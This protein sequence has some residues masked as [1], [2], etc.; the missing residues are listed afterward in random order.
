MPGERVGSDRAA[1]REAENGKA[2]VG[3][4]LTDEIS[5]DS[6][7]VF[8]PVSKSVWSGASSR[9]YVSTHRSGPDSAI[10]IGYD[11]ELDKTFARAKAGGE[12]SRWGD[13]VAVEAPPPPPPELTRK[14][15]A[16]ADDEESEARSK[17]K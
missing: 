12:D 13:W 1:Q 16:K 10:Q 9:V 14:G 11:P 6:R 8:D 5:G 15:K 7:E 2:R 4:S 3:L 17:K